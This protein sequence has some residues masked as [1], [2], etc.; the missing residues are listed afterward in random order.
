M[1]KVEFISLKDCL[2]PLIIFDFA[3][4]CN[5]LYF[6]NTRDYKGVSLT[7]CKVLVGGVVI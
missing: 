4:L 2:L 5:L 6:R 3:Q 7:I 1:K